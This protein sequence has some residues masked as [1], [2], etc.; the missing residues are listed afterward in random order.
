MFI[1][2]PSVPTIIPKITKKSDD[3]DEEM[4]DEDIM[5]KLTEEEI[6]IL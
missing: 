4:S 3:E 5:E 6:K 2:D 1:D